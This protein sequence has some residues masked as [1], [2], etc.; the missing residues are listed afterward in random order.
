MGIF[1]KA[2]K[3]WHLMNPKEP[4][5]RWAIHRKTHKQSTGKPTVI[6]L[7]FTCFPRIMFAF[8]AESR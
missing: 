6:H 5:N 3:D 7:L 2:H 1:A 8:D 4:R